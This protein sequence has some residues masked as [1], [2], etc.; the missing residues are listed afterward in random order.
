MGA[1]LVS[2]LDEFV[3]VEPMDVDLEVSAALV[4]TVGRVVDRVGLVVSAELVLLSK[5]LLLVGDCVLL[6]VRMAFVVAAVVVGV[7]VV[8]I[9]FTAVVHLS[10]HMVTLNVS[11]VPPAGHHLASGTG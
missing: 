6:A 10:Q 11:F 3:P 1:S 8:A 7:A 4:V 9:G 2:F 5:V